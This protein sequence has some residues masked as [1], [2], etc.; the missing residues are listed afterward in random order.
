[1]CVYK[2]LTKPVK[3][4]EWELGAGNYEYGLIKRYYEISMPLSLTE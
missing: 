4:T 1:M 3:D 2:V